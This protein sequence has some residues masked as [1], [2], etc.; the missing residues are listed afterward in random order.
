VRFGTFEYF[1]HEKRFKALEALAEYAIAE[2]Y[3]HLKGRTDR[4][5]HFFSEVVERTA[6]LMAE[7]M[8]V[9]FNHG[10]MNTDNMSIHGL[11]IDYGPYAF[12]DDYDSS[13]ICNHTDHNGRYSF[14]NQPKAGEWNLRALMAAL[15]PLVKME[16]ME[17][18]LVR[19]GRLYTEHYLSLM[20]KKLGL[21]EMRQHDGELI[22]HL[23]RVL[24]DLSVD[25]TVFF[26]RLSRYA[27]KRDALLELGLYHKPMHGWLDAYDARLKENT[28]TD[29][30]RHTRMLKCN[31]KYVLKNYMLQEAIEKAQDGD[32]SVVE[33]L[34]VIAQEPYGEHPEFERWAGVTPEAFKNRKLSCSS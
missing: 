8:A 27:G 13:N 31:P 30:E 33:N 7:W 28:L 5:L 9:G 1:T 16:R 12:L 6:R 19:F 24:Q 25:Y 11:T 15:S 32:F 21:D 23:L 29:E 17:K 2:S 10:V 22:T 34:F 20:G 14:S 3:P 26:R 18:S 4:Y